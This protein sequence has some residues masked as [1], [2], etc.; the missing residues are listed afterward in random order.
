MTTRRK[1]GT[2]TIESTADGRFRA[3]FPFET[4]SRETVGVY[5]TEAEA[6]RVLDSICV[7]L[8][9]SGRGRGTPLRTVVQKTH[10]ERRA[11]GY[12][13]VASDEERWL[14]YFAKHELASCPVQ[15]LTEGDVVDAIMAFRKQRG[16]GLLSLS[17]RKNILNMLRAALTVAKRDGLVA[18]NVLATTR[19]H[20][21]KGK[22]KKATRRVKRRALSWEAFGALWRASKMSPGIVIAVWTG[23]RQGELRA[24]HW[25]DVHNVG[26]VACTCERHDS[27]PHVVVRYGKPPIEAVSSEDECSPKNGETRTVALWGEALRAFETMH[28]GGVRNPRQIVFVSRL[29]GYRAKGRLFGRKEWSEWKAA[30][31]VSCRPHDLRHTCGTWLVRGETRMGID[32]AWPLEAVKEHLGHSELATTERYADQ[33]DGDQA[34]ERA[35]RARANDKPG[36]SPGQIAQVQSHLRGLN[37]RPTVYEPGAISSAAHSISAL[38]GLARAYVTAVERGDETAHAA[39]LTLASAVLNAESA[40]VR[41]VAAGGSR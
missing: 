6:A 18:T 4:G 34:R 40:A 29:R 30:A 13:S 38:A 12:A 9:E 8:R 31:G 33:R 7:E 39:G 17:T 41:T 36:T 28:R 32:G 14:T 24:L 5:D 15:D 25:P 10:E 3:R 16:G 2:G 27:A 26:G 1:K 23:M 11:A 37:S 35:A 21:P 19:F 20:D 22:G